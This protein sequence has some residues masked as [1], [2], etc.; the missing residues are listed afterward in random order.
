VEYVFDDAGLGSAGA[1]EDEQ[2]FVVEV[3]DDVY[4]DVFACQVECLFNIEIL[5]SY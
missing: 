3:L 4:G 1:F 5:L 2:A